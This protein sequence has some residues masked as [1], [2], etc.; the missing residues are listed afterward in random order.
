MGL[1]TQNY[2]RC[3]L[4][5]IKDSEYISTLTEASKNNMPEQSR[6][7]IE[8]KT[9]SGPMMLIIEEQNLRALAD[10]LNSDRMLMPQNEVRNC[11]KLINTAIPH[12]L[13]VG[14]GTKTVDLGAGSACIGGALR[15]R[16]TE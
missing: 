12:V 16:G 14:G 9:A 2:L 13:D 10:W 3:G 8:R 5:D 7:P 11:L 6:D 1:S 15:G 4:D